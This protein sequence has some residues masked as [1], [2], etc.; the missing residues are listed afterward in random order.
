MAKRKYVGRGMAAKAQQRTESRRSFTAKKQ[1]RFF[2][3]LART[4]NAMESARIAKVG[5]STIWHW[6]QKNA[7]FAERYRNAL[8]EGYAD[9]EMRLL[10]I[11]RFGVTSEKLERL[12]A[13]GGKSVSERRDDPRFGLMLL[14]AHRPDAQPPVDPAELAIRIRAALIEVQ[15]AGKTPALPTP[16]DADATDR[17]GGGDDAG[18]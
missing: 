5:Y 18:T 6:R 9:L 10:A 16:A 7:A 11:A 2:E 17:K 3:A 14:R 12:N 8:D 1:D 4:A 15:A 13:D